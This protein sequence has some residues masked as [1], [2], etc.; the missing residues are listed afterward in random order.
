MPARVASFAGAGSRHEPVRLR[1]LRDDDAAVHG[2]RPLRRRGP[3]GPGASR[4]LPGLHEALPLRGAPTPL[5]AGRRRR[6]DAAGFEAAPRRTPLGAAAH[7][8]TVLRAPAIPDVYDVTTV[9]CSISTS[10]VGKPLVFWTSVG[11][12][13]PPP[14]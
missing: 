11:K 10:W 12:S 6:A 7:L 2:R 4:R 8:S 9:A 14:S 5:R 13:L 1:R 3:R